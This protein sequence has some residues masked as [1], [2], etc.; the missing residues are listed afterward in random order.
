MV[1][2]KELDIAY[3]DNHCPDPLLTPLCETILRG[4]IG[5]TGHA[6]NPIDH[7]LIARRREFRSQEHAASL[8]D[9]RSLQ[10]IHNAPDLGPSRRSCRTKATISTQKRTI[11][12]DRKQQMMRMLPKHSSKTSSKLNNASRDEED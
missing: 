12:R 5:E 9:Q 4:R 1:S 11:Q 3:A 2:L 6:T 7:D 8:A 10:R